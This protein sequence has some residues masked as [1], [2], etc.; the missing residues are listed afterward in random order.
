[1]VTQVKPLSAINWARTAN[2]SQTGSRKIACGR[3]AMTE[4]P[5]L[6]VARRGLRSAGSLDESRAK[7]IRRC[8]EFYRR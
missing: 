3:E 2:V 6:F 7:R 1:M 4:D 5:Q 8:E